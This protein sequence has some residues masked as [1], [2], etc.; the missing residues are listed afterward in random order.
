MSGQSPYI[1]NASVGYHNS[2]IGLDV[3][4]VYN[5][6]GPK[7]IINV[8]GGTPNIYQ[9]PVNNINFVVSKK[10]TKHFDLSFKA[11]NLLNPN[12]KQTYTYKGEE[13]ISRQYKMGRV[14][15]VGIKYGI[16]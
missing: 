9:Q 12:N 7:L 3:N 2:N 8:M 1:I 13:Y 14:F 15:E 10:L 5:V 11:T 16:N 4:A 6:A